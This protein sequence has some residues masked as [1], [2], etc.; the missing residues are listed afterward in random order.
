[1]NL[2]QKKRINNKEYPVFVTAGDG[3]QKLAHI[4]HN[5]YLN[6]CYKTLASIAG[7]LVVFGFGF[8]KYDEHI[9]EAINKAAQ[10]QIQAKILF[11]RYG[12]NMSLKQ[13]LESVSNTT[14]C[15]T[16]S[17][18]GLTSLKM[19]PNYQFKNLWFVTGYCQS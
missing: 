5:Q 12:R 14:F 15:W 7:S 6:Y 3:K 4:L 10:S 16:K 8:G 11:R 13:G 17:I 1:M 9:I 2:F 19:P 18:T